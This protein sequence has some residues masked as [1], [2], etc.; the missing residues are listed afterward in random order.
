MHVGFRCFI[1]V[2]SFFWHPLH[3][4]LVFKCIFLFFLPSAHRNLFASLCASLLKS[5]RPFTLLNLFVFL[6]AISLSRRIYK[7]V[8]TMLPFLPIN[9]PSLSICSNR[10]NNFRAPSLPSLS[11]CC[12]KSQIVR[13]IRYRLPGMQSQKYH[14]TK[15]I[16]HL[17]SHSSSLRP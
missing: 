5:F 8:S 17:N 10:S 1:V 11:Q 12:L 3:V 15:S 2:T 14:E 13:R 16:P 9:P 6:P 7:L 4:I